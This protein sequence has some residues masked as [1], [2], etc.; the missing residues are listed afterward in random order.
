MYSGKGKEERIF[1][2]TKRTTHEMLGIIGKKAGITKKVNHHK[3]RHAQATDMVRRGYNEAIIRR[4][5]GWTDT[6]P[7]ACKLSAPA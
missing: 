6:K 1:D 5:L 4:K 3:F 7:N 2:L